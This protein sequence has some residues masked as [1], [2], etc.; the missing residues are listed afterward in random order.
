MALSPAQLE[1]RRLGYGAS[2]VATIVG[3]GPGKLIEIY[4]AKRSPITPA[5]VEE[6]QQL[7]RDLGELLEEPAAKIYARRTKTWLAPVDTLQHPTK[8]LALATPDRARFITESAWQRAREKLMRLDGAG[9]D[10]ESVKECERL[11]EVKTTGSK[12]RR[13][14]GPNGSAVVPP[15]KAI[16]VTWQMG[17]TGVRVVDLPVL[18]IT[19]FKREFAVFTVTFNED[20]FEALYAQVERFHVDYVLAGVPPPPDGSDEYHDFLQRSQPYV[21]RGAISASAEDEDLIMRFALFREAEKRAGK[22]KERLGQ[23]LKLIMGDAEQMIS[24]R[25]GKLRYGRTEGKQIT[26]WQKA[27]G[28]AAQLAALCINAFEDSENKRELEA[29]LKAI[30]PANTKQGAG[31]RALNLYPKG[32]ADLE[33]ARLNLMIDAL[34]E[35]KP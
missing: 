19:D 9:L 11:V 24:A 33:L 13:S 5:E 21:R 22:L 30:L 29:T 31:Y 20:L 26:D 32:E 1:K 27:Y 6:D 25:Y 3:E 18:F 8:L 15:E 28:E 23:Q 12:H 4:D 14:Y 17:V 16:Q 7:A 35:V 34:D 10:L 2:E